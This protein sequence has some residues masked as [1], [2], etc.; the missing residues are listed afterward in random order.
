MSPDCAR[1]PDEEDA[2]MLKV[3][4]WERLRANLEA[5]DRRIDALEDTT[6]RLRE[7]FDRIEEGIE[8]LMPGRLDATT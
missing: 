4:T 2:H 7:D 6:A 8:A 3:M 1:R 5:V